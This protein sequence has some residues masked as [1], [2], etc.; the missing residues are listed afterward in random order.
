M[1]DPVYVRR[2]QRLMDAIDVLTAYPS[3]ISIVDLAKRLEADV[4]ELRAEIQAYYVV[5]LTGEQLLGG[6][7]EPIIEFVPDPNGSDEYA[8]LST[9]E[10]LRLRVAGPP[11]QSRRPMPLSKLAELSQ[12]G[13]Q[14]A[15]LEPAN[16]HLAEALDELDRSVLN[17]VDISSTPWLTKIARPL[18][19]AMSER[20][21]VR[22]RYAR[23]WKPGV[24]ERVVAPYRIT[25]TRRGWEVDAGVADSDEVRTYLVSGIESLDVLDETFDVPPDID[26]RIAANRTVRQVRIVVP[27][28]MAWAVETYAESAEV[29]AEDE[30]LVSVKAEILEPAATRVA[31]MMLSSG[32]P[33]DAFVVEPPE[34]D[35]AAKDLARELLDHHTDAS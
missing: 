16:E 13:H 10:Y 25:N 8:D 27:Y 35:D 15:A 1:S 34:L 9:A 23:L 11:G 22:I 29:T 17:G 24:V 7:F 2:F 31:L 18:Q 20:R 5:E 12:I 33:A 3:G 19:Q 28:G 21:F 4:E 32:D 30:E 6:H 14:Q 26:A